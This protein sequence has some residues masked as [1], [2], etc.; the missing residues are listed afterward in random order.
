MKIKLVEIMD[1]LNDKGVCNLFTYKNT[2]IG[3]YIA[4]NTQVWLMGDGVNDS[5]SNMIR[6]YG[7]VSI[8]FFI[9]K[10]IYSLKVKCLIANPDVSKDLLLQPNSGRATMSSHNPSQRLYINE[11]PKLSN[12]RKSILNLQYPLELG[13][14]QIIPSAIK[15]VNKTLKFHN[16]ALIELDSEDCFDS[17]FYYDEEDQLPN[18]DDN[19]LL[20]NPDGSRTT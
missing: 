9:D 17:D 4:A 12:N 15:N 14:T 20:P 1:A 3:T 7:L 16:I 19:D 6:N 10:E 13:L 2:G 11:S 5:Y 8:I 18:Y